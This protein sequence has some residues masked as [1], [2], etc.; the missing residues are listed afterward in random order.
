MLPHHSVRAPFRM[1]RWSAR[2]CQPV[3][4]SVVLPAA[5][6]SAVDQ[7]RGSKSAEVR[8]I[9]EVYDECLQV[10]HPRF[11]GEICTALLA[12]DVSLAWNVWSFSV[13]VSLVR[14]FIA[15]GGSLPA[16]GVRL[17]RGS[18]QFKMVALGGSV[19]GTLRSDI[20]WL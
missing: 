13:E 16:S 5:W 7:T 11:W 4:Y 12:G 14:A 8:R 17:G 6:V 2:F 15:A 1:G 20:F 3:R 19:V 10:V 9:W 18:A